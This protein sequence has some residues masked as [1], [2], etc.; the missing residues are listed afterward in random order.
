MARRKTKTDEDEDVPE[1]VE[2]VNNDV[3]L[4]RSASRYVA[5]LR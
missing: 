2:I 3:I 1:V 5:P 4:P